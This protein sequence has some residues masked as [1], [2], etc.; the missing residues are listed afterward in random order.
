MRIVTQGSMTA[1]QLGKVIAEI[2]N[3]TLEKAEVKG[4]RQ[5]IHNA[6]V[7]FNL[8]LQGYDEPQLITVEDGTKMFTVHT[9]VKNG[10]LTEYVPVD[11]Q[12]LVDKFNEMVDNGVKE[13]EEAEE[14]KEAKE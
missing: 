2:L 10:E 5:P 4:K 11:R 12:E 14:P 7:E 3:D 6:V 9:G 1:N 8:N 13:M